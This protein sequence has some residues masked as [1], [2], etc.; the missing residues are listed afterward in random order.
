MNDLNA[1]L[2]KAKADL[3]ALAK[4]R[5]EREAAQ[6]ATDRVEAVERELADAIA[7]DAAVAEHG[8]LGKMIAAI[9]TDLGVVIVKRPHAATF[10][11]FQDTGSMKSA[12]LEKLVRPCLVH[13]DGEKFGALLEQLPATLLRVANVVTELAGMRSAEVSGKS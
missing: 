12:D 8:P 6:A 5:A 1:R 7:I 3:D 10:R 9:D 11:K 4:K 13:P 2:A